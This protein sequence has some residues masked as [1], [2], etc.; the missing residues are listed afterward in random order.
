METR[1]IVAA[2]PLLAATLCCGQPGTPAPDRI[3]PQATDRLDLTGFDVAAAGDWLFVSLPQE[4][5]MGFNSGAVAPFRFDVSTGS[6]VG[7]P[8]VESFQSYED[9]YFGI[10]VAAAP[11]TLVVGCPQDSRVALGGGYVEVFTRSGQQWVFSHGVFPFS[12]LERGDLF[13]SSVALGGDVLVVG[14]PS[15]RPNGPYS[16]RAAVFRRSGGFFSPVAELERG[17]EDDLY[18]WSVA[19]GDGFVAVG[20]FNIDGNTYSYLGRGIVDVY[21]DIGGVWTLVA[22]L[23]QDVPGRNERFAWSMD[24]AA[25]VIAVGAHNEG[26]TGVNFD[27]AGAVYTFEKIGG[28]WTRT[29]RLEAPDAGWNQQFGFDV[30]LSPDGDSLLIGAKNDPEAGE[31]AGAIYAF[32]RDGSSWRFSRKI[33]P[34]V[35]G[36]P[37]ERVEFGYSVAITTNSA[38]DTWLF[39]GAPES[40]A[41]GFRA[42]DVYASPLDGCYADCDGS[43][44]LDV[45]DLLCF[46][47][48]FA[49]NDP[50]ADCDGSTLLDVFDLLCFQDAFTAGCP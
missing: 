29:A 3:T 23:E 43:G 15:A 22:T 4:S 47:D 50:R 36:P 48:L 32:E 20:S 12:P 1:P 16:G 21:E 9:Q 49:A 30:D 14:S 24:A 13:G 7:M 28:A 44:T 42:G 35:A 37:A 10:A 25:G 11:D 26:T 19:V 18:G 33:T 46:Q 31:D 39:G 17:D 27:G 34:P 8:L 38:G 40:D 2:V 6:W 45:F 5:G 41:L